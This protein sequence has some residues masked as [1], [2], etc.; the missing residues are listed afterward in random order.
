M[1]QNDDMISRQAAIDVLDAYQ[2]MVENGEENPYAW[3]RER[4]CELSSAQP[5]RLDD[6]DFETIRIHLSACKEK[7]CNQHRWKEAEEYQ[8]IIDRFM[9]F[10][11][12]EPERKIG[13]F[14]R[15]ME[16]R[17]APGYIS[18]TPHCKCS[19]CGNELSIENIN[20]CYMCGARLVEDRGAERRE[21]GGE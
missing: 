14:V 11:S 4:M 15:W 13:K 6:D 16:K 20:Y 21:E 2:V 17:E 8:R 18:Y 7:L 12:A 9:A 10:A 1:S 19:L 5:D 3:A